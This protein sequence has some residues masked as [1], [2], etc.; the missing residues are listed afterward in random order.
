MF[1]IVYT[2]IIC[3][4]CVYIHMYVS[5]CRG[6]IAFLEAICQCIQ[7]VC[8]CMCVCVCLCIIQFKIFF[9]FIFI[10]WRLITLQYCSG[11]CHTL[12]DLH[13]FPI[14]KPPPASLPIP[15]LWVFPVHQPLALI[16]C[17]QP[18]LVVCFTLDSILVSML[19]SQNIPPSP[20]PS[21]SQSLFCTSVSLFL[22]CIQGYHYHLFKFHIYAL[23]YCIGLYL[24]GLLH[25]V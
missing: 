14:L 7:C 6:Y 12:N 8:I 1:T 2:Y 20:Y 11:F 22:F 4:M 19:F 10:S 13:V 23:V 15:S 16:S 5:L 18:G 9:P 3:V 21:E 17:I 24:S 25:S